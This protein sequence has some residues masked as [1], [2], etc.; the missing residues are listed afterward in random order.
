M[1]AKLTIDVSKCMITEVYKDIVCGDISDINTPDNGYV[2]E[3]PFGTY[4]YTIV[5]KSIDSNCKKYS[6]SIQDAKTL[7]YATQNCEYI[8]K[9]TNDNKADELPEL[10]DN[11]FNDAPEVIGAIFK[12][13]TP[14]KDF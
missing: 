4:I 14:S 1:L 6:D 7:V 5:E 13:N 8:T 9:V 11:Y 3:T 12:A 2:V 10:C